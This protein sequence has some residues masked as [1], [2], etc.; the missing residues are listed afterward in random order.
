MKVMYIGSSGALSLLPFKKL[1]EASC[2]IVTVGIYKPVQFDNKII[3][4]ENE[5]LALAA[6]QAGIPVIDLSLP[7]G[8]IVKLCGSAVIDVMFMSCYARRLP[9]E[10]IELAGKG[11]FNMHPSLLPAYRGPEP[12]FWQMKH[13]SDLGVSWHR[14]TSE[15]DEG[16]IA[17]QQKVVIDDGLS[18]AQISQQLAARGA[19]LL[20]EMLPEIAAGKLRCR[21]QAEENSSYFSYPLES[22][23]VIDTAYSARQLY[24]F[25]RA[26]KEFGYV[27]RYRY[28]HH[29]YD[30][31]EALDFKEDLTLDAVVVK[32]DSLHIPCND[33][34]LIASYI[35][36]INH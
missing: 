7:P 31:T 14:V 20:L 34:V 9:D 28:D 5:S 21:S 35:D 26:T 12:V 27:Y 22:D 6:Q 10:I 24:N 8:E 33:G 18:H 36:K 23:F 32:T 16:A 2:D 29:V 30:L 25:M 19:M 15:F 1:L 11:C 17:A 3:A 13:A 4:L